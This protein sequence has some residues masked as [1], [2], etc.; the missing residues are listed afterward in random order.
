MYD[1]VNEHCVMNLTKD[2]SNVWS[3]KLKYHLDNLGLS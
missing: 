1:I 3:A 2:Y